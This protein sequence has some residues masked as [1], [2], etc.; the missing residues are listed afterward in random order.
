AVEAKEYIGMMEA[1]GFTN[2]SVTPVF[3]D[4]ET[5]DGAIDEVKDQIDLSALSAVSRDDIY[6]AVFSAKITAYKPV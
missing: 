5:V 6:K 4:K 2:I 1:A 3:F